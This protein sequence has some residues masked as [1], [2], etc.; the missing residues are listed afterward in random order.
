MWIRTAADVD[1]FIDRIKAMWPNGYPLTASGP[2][3]MVEE[4]L[5]LAVQDKASVRREEIIKAFL[6]YSFKDAA[7]DHGGLTETEKGI[8]TREEFDALVAWLKGG[9]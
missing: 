9:A 2:L 4:E 1:T 5:K 7:F 3:S 6:H 8:C